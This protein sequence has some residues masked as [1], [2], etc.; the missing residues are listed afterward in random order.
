M[1]LFIST[2]NT[3]STVINIYLDKRETKNRM[4][5]AIDD[6]VRVKHGSVSYIWSTCI[7]VYSW[8]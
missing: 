6:R 2:T 1:S 8:L 4:V 3:G 5:I 7:T